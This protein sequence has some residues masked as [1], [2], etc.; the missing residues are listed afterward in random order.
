MQTNALNMRL[1]RS[2]QTAQKNERH[3]AGFANAPVSEPNATG[4]NG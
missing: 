1:T 2:R 3:G 4:V